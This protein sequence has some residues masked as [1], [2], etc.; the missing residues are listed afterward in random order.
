MN[1]LIKDDKLLKKYDGIWEKVINII[2]KVVDSDPVYN[3][4]M[5]KK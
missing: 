2:C 5:Y 3:E 4:K 1:F